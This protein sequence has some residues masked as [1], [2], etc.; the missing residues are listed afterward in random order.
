MARLGRPGLSGAQRRE[1][2]ERWKAGDSISE[3]SRALFKNPGSVHGALAQGGGI[4]RFE[5]L[6]N[7]FSVRWF[8]GL[9]N[10]IPAVWYWLHDTIQTPTVRPK[11]SVRVEG[12]NQFEKWGGAL[13]VGVRLPEFLLATRCQFCVVRLALL[14]GGAV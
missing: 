6:I 11:P 9:D 5:W 7:G 8:I 14:R 10:V 4:Y 12:W 13:G 2:W 3:I 1:L